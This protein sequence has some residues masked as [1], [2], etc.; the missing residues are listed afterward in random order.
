[1]AVR[2][3]TR[4]ARRRPPSTPACP[5]PSEC[6][7][8]IAVFWGRVLAHRLP[9]PEYA[10]AD[11][12]AYESG[13]VWELE[14]GLDVSRQCRPSACPHLPPHAP[15]SRSSSPSPTPTSD[16]RG[17]DR[18]RGVLRQLCRSGHGDDSTAFSIYEKPD[19]FR[20]RIE[21]DVRTLVKEVLD[22]DT[23]APLPRTDTAPSSRWK[24]SPFPGLRSFTPAD[25]PI[26]FGRGRE[27][28]LLASRACPSSP[29]V[30]VIGASGSGKSSVVGAGLIPRLAEADPPLLLP[31][32]DPDTRQW[33]G[34]RAHTQRVSDLI[35]SSPSP[36]ALRPSCTTSRASI[37]ARLRATP[38]SVLESLEI[39]AHTGHSSSSTSSKS[40]FTVVDEE[41]RDR[42][43]A[44]ARS[45]R[46][47]RAAPCGGHPALG[48]LPAM[49]RATGSCPPDGGWPDPRPRHRPT[50][51]SR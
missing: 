46:R 19:D 29:F 21:S 36:C 50:R 33:D 13:S 5:A 41:H 4:P 34:L 37:V 40:L 28:D 16:T 11:G 10:R 35:P 42:F 49:R 45:R 7:V 9:H 24:G 25:A 47:G 14:D 48:L 15:R 17:T 38:A 3:S 6:D 2:H 30:A 20:Q 31:T 27:T 39:A 8:V 26:F 1:M 44:L 43:I 22:G 32:V 23:A 12:D 51:C 18:V